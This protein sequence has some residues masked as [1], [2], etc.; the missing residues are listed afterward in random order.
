MGVLPMLHRWLARDY[1]GLPA[2]SVSFIRWSMTDVM[3]VG[4]LP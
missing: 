1:E 3:P 2:S 4:S